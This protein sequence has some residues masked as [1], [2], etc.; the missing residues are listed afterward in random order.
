MD[1]RSSI[2]LTQ[3]RAWARR[4]YVLIYLYFH[5]FKQDSG[6]VQALKPAIVVQYLETT[7][8][9]LSL[10]LVT[11]FLNVP[12]V[13]PQWQSEYEVKNACHQE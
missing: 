12:I 11:A 5:R 3:Q 9:S 1:K 4:L 10:T 2:V 13:Q 7:M 6:V 8:T